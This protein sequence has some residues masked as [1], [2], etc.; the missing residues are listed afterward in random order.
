[1]SAEQKAMEL[2]AQAEK[3]AKSGGGFMSFFGGGSSKQEDAAELYVRAANSFKMAKQWANAGNA[4]TQAA[5]INLQLGNKHEA[6]TQYVDAGNCYRKGDPHEA[7]NCLHKAIEI[8]T[9]MGKFTIAAK[10][11]ITI[12]EICETEI[13]DIEKS[14]QNYQQAADYYKGEESNSSAN[15]CLLKVAQYASQQQQYEKAIEIY[16]QV[17]TS[18]MDNQLLRYSAKD[19][20]FRAAICRMCVEVADAAT[21][22]AKYEQMFPQFSDSRECKLLKTL[23][24]ACEDQSPDAFSEAIQ[25]YDSISRLDPWYTSLLVRVKKSLEGQEDLK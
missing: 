19:H 23:V 18:S 20:F 11:H 7:V 16:E 22:I 13:V 1:M 2:M 3:K 21:N 24:Q 4:F 5:K 10:H 17:G 9:D 25:Q 6:G 12:A 8:Y 14:M 15:K